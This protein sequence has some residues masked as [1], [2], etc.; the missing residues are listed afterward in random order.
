M[1]SEQ[2]EARE[3]QLHDVAEQVGD[4]FLAMQDMLDDVEL[5]DLLVEHDDVSAI[6]TDTNTFDWQLAHLEVVGVEQVGPNKLKVKVAWTVSGEQD[7]DKMYCGTSAHGTAD[8][9]V[10]PYKPLELENV[11]A[12]AEDYRE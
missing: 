8:V 12:N 4:A 1:S 9:L 11:V 5:S 6:M 3:Q 2:E 7:E 10:E